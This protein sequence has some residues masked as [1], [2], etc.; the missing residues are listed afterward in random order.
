MRDRD[1]LK[2]HFV[3]NPKLRGGF[4]SPPSGLPHTEPA[5]SVA[6]W[7]IEHFVSQSRAT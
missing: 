7:M 4:L 5:Q 6:A 3:G 1:T 2:E